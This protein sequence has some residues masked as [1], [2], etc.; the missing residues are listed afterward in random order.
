MYSR[1][2]YVIFLQNAK[3][4]AVHVSKYWLCFLNEHLQVEKEVTP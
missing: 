2:E 1:N 4:M 3:I